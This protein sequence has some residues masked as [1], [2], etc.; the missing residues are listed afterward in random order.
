MMM[1]YLQG[2]RLSNSFLIP[3]AGPSCS[4]AD[5]FTQRMGFISL[6]YLGCSM[7]GYRHPVVDKVIHINVGRK[8]FYSLYPLDNYLVDV[9]FIRWINLK[10]RTIMLL[11]QEVHQLIFPQPIKQ[12]FLQSLHQMFTFEQYFDVSL[13]IGSK[14]VLLK[15]HLLMECV[16]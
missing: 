3:Q 12:L 10:D 2:N 9:S 16:E 8:R 6:C 7:L 11:L 5:D 14:R 4:R 15:I 1:Y 13:F